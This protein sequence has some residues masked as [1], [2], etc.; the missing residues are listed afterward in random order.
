MKT[1]NENLLAYLKR[2]KGITALEALSRFGCFRAA[3]RI[4]ELREQG[5]KIKSEMITV[6][7]KRVAKYSL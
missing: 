6:N 1:Q 3:S 2:G 4:N 5:Y 7:G